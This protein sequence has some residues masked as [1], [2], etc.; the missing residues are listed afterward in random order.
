M[1]K[2]MKPLLGRNSRYHWILLLISVLTML[3][4]TKSSPLY[5]LNDWVDSN[6]IFTVGKSL[7][8]GKIVYRDLFDHKGP[9]LHFIYAIGALISPKS[10]FGLWL[11]EI[12]ACYFTLLFAYRTVRLFADERS[13]LVMPLF[14]VLVYSSRAMCHGGSAEEF[15]LPFVTCAIYIAVKSL[16][17][18][19]PISPKELMVIGLTASVVFWIK[20]TMLGLYIGWVLLPLVVAIKEKNWKFIRNLFLIIPACLAAV[21]IPVIGFFLIVGAAPDLFQTYFYANLFNYKTSAQEGANFIIV[22]LKSMFHNYF[23]WISFVFGSIWML[24][25][26]HYLIVAQLLLTAGVGLLLTYFKFR[27]SAYHYYHLIFCGF[28]LF[29]LIALY[30][31]LSKPITA[32]KAKTHITLAVLCCVLILPLCYRQS[33]NSYLLFTPKEETPQY[34][35][36]QIINAKPDATFLN[37]SA[38]DAGVYTVSGLVPSNKYFCTMNLNIDQCRAEQDALVENGAV[39]FVMTRGHE[40]GSDLYEEVKMVSFFFEG[41]THDYRLYQRKAEN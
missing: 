16:K 21:S 29:G 2:K 32:L 5:P 27:D 17:E 37:Y 4:C 19:T 23:I 7:W 12:V 3:I 34:Q 33:S 8:S 15:C 41:S 10:F 24:V 1:E 6:A 13:I 30:S 11:I 35:F 31:I 40:L 22:I 9:L 14:A 36:A 18:K 25:K 28:G 26:K 20:Y 39:D 38:M